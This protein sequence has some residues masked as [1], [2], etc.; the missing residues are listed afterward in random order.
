MQV[1]G[2]CHCGAIKFEAEVDP[3]KA[4]I[5]HC[6]D[7]QALSATAFRVNVP[8]TAEDFR[9]LQGQPKEY[10]KIGDSGGRR[11]Q[12][13][14]GDCGAQIYATNADGARE[15]YM[16]RAGVIAERD[17][18]PPKFQAWSQSALTWLGDLPNIPSRPKG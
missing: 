12:G 6:V 3:E 17:Q 1:N 4:M 9:L 8:S 14:C 16:L 5:C 11:A 10:V 15:V 18:L 2:G 7:C 13:F